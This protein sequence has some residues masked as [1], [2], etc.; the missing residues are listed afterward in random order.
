MMSV[1]TLRPQFGQSGRFLRRFGGW[2]LHRHAAADE[3]DAVFPEDG[4]PRD[5]PA[6]VDRPRS[7]ARIKGA[8]TWRFGNREGPQDRPGVGLS[9]FG[10]RMIRPTVPIARPVFAACRAGQL[11][12]Y[13]I[14]MPHAHVEILSRSW[15]DTYGEVAE[16]SKAAHLRCAYETEHNYVAVAT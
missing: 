10:S 16:R 1:S 13:V 4:Q 11:G 9:G 2:V 8:G 14:F 12:R 7:G 6:G 3:R 5:W 15:S